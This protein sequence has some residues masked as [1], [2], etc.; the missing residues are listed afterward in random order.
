VV[1]PDGTL[2]PF[3][4]RE[5]YLRRIDFFVSLDSRPKGLLRTFSRV[6]KKKKKKKERAMML[7]GY[8]KLMIPLPDPLTTRRR[9]RT[10]IDSSFYYFCTTKSIFV[11]NPN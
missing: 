3:N 8:A 1:T 9:S 6:I 2:D 4:P 10:Q 5:E 7:W 11:R